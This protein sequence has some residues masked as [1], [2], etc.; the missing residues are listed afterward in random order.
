MSGKSN[1]VNFSAIKHYR[2]T[3]G[4]HEKYFCKDANTSAREQQATINLMAEHPGLHRGNW[5]RQVASNALVR[6]VGNLQNTHDSIRAGSSSSVTNP[7]TKRDNNFPISPSTSLQSSSRSQPSCNNMNPLFPITLLSSIRSNAENEKVIEIK[8]KD[9]KLYQSTKN[10]QNKSIKETQQK[11]NVAN[12]QKNLSLV[13]QIKVHDSSIQSNQPTEIHT[14][15][16]TY[17]LASDKTDSTSINQ[18]SQHENVEVSDNSKLATSLVANNGVITPSSEISV[19]SNQPT[20]LLTASTLC[21]SACQQ[22][23]AAMASHSSQLE[24][25]QVTLPLMAAA[26]GYAV[27]RA[28]NAISRR[29]M[30]A[31]MAALVTTAAAGWLY[32]RQNQAKLIQDRENEPPLDSEIP[33][34]LVQASLSRNYLDEKKDPEER[35]Q[36][37][38]LRVPGYAQIAELRTQLFANAHD[39][40]L[41]NK[42]IQYYNYAIY[43]ASHSKEVSAEPIETRQTMFLTKIIQILNYISWLSPVERVNSW[44]NIIGKLSDYTRLQGDTRTLAECR[45]FN[46]RYLHKEEEEI[47]KCNFRVTNRI[48]VYGKKLNIDTLDISDEQNQ[49]VIL[50]EQ[51][52]IIA[53]FLRKNGLMSEDE[54]DENCN[55]VLLN[56]LSNKNSSIDK[57]KQIDEIYTLIKKVFTENTKLELSDER[58]SQE[59]KLKF[60]DSFIFNR[61]MGSNFN[62][63]LAVKFKSLTRPGEKLTILDFG[64]SVLNIIEKKNISSQEKKYIIEKFILAKFPYLS[65]VQARGDSSASEGR[66]SR[67]RDS[68]ES[69]YNEMAG[70]SIDSAKYLLFHAGYIFNIKLDGDLSAS[71]LKELGKFV[72]QT[73]VSDEELERESFA[74]YF[75]EPAALAS[76]NLTSIDFY[77]KDE[78]KNNLQTIL[79][80]SYEKISNFILENDANYQFLSKL[81]EWEPRKVLAKRLMEEKIYSKEIIASYAA[82]REAHPELKFPD[83]VSDT[84]VDK[85]LEYGTYHE[86]Y[87]LGYLN[88]ILKGLPNI[89][90][91]FLDIDK[92]LAASF[93]DRQLEIFIGQLVEKIKGIKHFL[94]NSDVRKIDIPNEKLAELNIPQLKVLG[95]KKESFYLCVNPESGTYI[96]RLD[97]KPQEQDVESEKSD[98]QKFK[99]SLKLEESLD[100]TAVHPIQKEMEKLINTELD[101]Q[102]IFLTSGTDISELS[103]DGGSIKS[104]SLNLGQKITFDEVMKEFANKFGTEMERLLYEAGFGEDTTW[105]TWFKNLLFSAIPFYNAHELFSKG[106]YVTGTIMAGLDISGILNPFKQ[107]GKIALKKVVPIKILNNMLLSKKILDITKLINKGSQFNRQTTKLL[108]EKFITQWRFGAIN[109]LKETKDMMKK[110]SAKSSVPTALNSRSQNAVQPS[111]IPFDEL[112]RAQ[113]GIKFKNFGKLFERK[114]INQQRYQVFKHSKNKQNVIVVPVATENEKIIFENIHRDGVKFIL[115]DSGELQEV[116]VA[117]QPSKSVL[118][119]MRK[120]GNEAP[121]AGGLKNVF[122]G[123]Y[124]GADSTAVIPMQGFNCQVTQKKFADSHYV[125]YVARGEGN[126]AVADTLVIS[127]H[128]HYFDSDLTTV[129]N[130]PADVSVQFLAPHDYF[131]WDPSLEVVINGEY[132]PYVRLRKGKQPEVNLHSDIPANKENIPEDFLSTDPKNVQGG[133]NGLIN[134]RHTSFLVETP[135]EVGRLLAKNRQ[136]AAEGKISTISD[137]LLVGDEI[138]N[139]GL[140]FDSG[141]D[142]QSVLND[143]VSGKFVNANGVKYKEVAFCHCRVHWSNKLSGT[144]YIVPYT[145]ETEAKA[146]FSKLKKRDLNESASMSNIEDAEIGANEFKSVI[147]TYVLTQVGDTKIFKVSLNSTIPVR[148]VPSVESSTPITS[149]SSE[150]D[151]K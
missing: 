58:S 20:E 16:K 54:P 13:N 103:I 41:S 117:Q 87:D 135:E 79:S 55:K 142:V 49:R 69:I 26:A 138:D 67:E 72:F 119:P 7:S 27:H 85:Y 22:T 37:K 131:L 147:E 45:K 148:L 3:L 11:K 99:E 48:L 2:K 62:K 101:P 44:E 50:N 136:L 143:I 98:C 36:E 141:T 84:L 29:S 151:T 19:R 133:E 65:I 18:L 10:R 71:E 15:T 95:S 9:N 66:T 59:Y 25:S 33:E 145:G 137:A 68:D 80:E 123:A 1:E 108:S 96:L 21:E 40:N 102:L 92:K 118:L 56:L 42:E 120:K 121:A 77:D 94:E 97:Q 88:E 32:L 93:Q 127:A 86:Q 70:L 12:R 134:Y 61:A 81:M 8:K 30:A 64:K 63:W 125:Q 51:T 28:D 5:H 43:T 31:G 124:E 150:S 57:E 39:F 106:C 104:T 105:G 139:I 78:V 74:R 91:L 60:I 47:L 111:N 4:Q 149:S 24:N 116:I 126:Q 6:L 83:I 89:D 76:S 75:L 128:G 46:E 17:E 115:N 53:E 107:A 90:Q 35:F 110:K 146:G 82:M 140:T 109:L 132:K 52:Q 100:E 23:D 144:Y 73:S 34:P 14:T 113:L 122:S 38:I 114:E 130:L 112:N 129:V